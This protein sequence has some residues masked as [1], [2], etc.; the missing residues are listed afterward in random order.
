MWDKDL[1]GIF[2]SEEVTGQGTPGKSGSWAGNLEICRCCMSQDMVSFQMPI[3]GESL[4]TLSQRAVTP[5]PYIM[6]SSCQEL[7]AASPRLLSC[8]P[9]I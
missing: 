4:L 1:A 5:S 6:L 3:W 7:E 8:D 9:R 2:P